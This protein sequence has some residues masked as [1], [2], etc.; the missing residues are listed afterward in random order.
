[1]QA[2]AQNTAD[3]AKE[4]KYRVLVII[5]DGEDFELLFTM[6]PKEAIRASKMKALAP[7]SLIGRIMDKKR[8]YRLITKGGFEEVP[9]AE[10][11]T[12]FR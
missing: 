4:K 10:G 6:S 2:F 9:E 11:Y 5:T 7:I 8:G 1:M 3:A 12:H